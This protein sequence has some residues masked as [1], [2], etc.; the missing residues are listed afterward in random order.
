M[1][2]V[3][4][5]T[6]GSRGIGRAIAF[7]LAADGMEV[8]VTYRDDADAAAETVQAVGGRTIAVRADAA[9]PE[10]LRGVLVVAEERFGGVD[11]IVHNAGAYTDGPL[12]TATDDDYE[13]VFAVNARAMFVLLREAATRVRDGG[14]IVYVSTAATRLKPP[15]QALY[16]AS[17]AAGEQ[18]VCT[19]A[20]EAGVRGI[21]ANSVLPGP[22]DT[23]TFAASGAPVNQLVGMTPLGRIGG[24]ADIADI[25]R[26]LASDASRWVTGQSIA[27]AGGLA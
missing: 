25:V 16:A 19:F 8:V 6:G 10:A 2:K 14:R 18:L 22:T 13:R 27:A 9:D 15:E 23:E 4:V 21:T 7:S 11:V 3:A 20:R 5:V 24:P 12:A 26:F 1:N 17:K